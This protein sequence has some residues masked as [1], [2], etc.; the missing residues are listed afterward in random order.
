MATNTGLL[1]NP[2]AATQQAPGTAPPVTPQTQPVVQQQPGQQQPMQ[3]TAAT[4]PT[5]NQAGTGQAV[6]QQVAPK[7]GN[8]P[9]ATGDP[10]FAQSVQDYESALG[11]DPSIHSVQGQL[12]GLLSSDNKLVQQSRNRA[13]LESAARGLRNSSVAV[14]AG[15]EAAYAAALPIAQADAELQMKSRLAAFGA[16]VEDQMLQK[17]HGFDL[18]KIEKEYQNNRG[19]AEQAFGFN[20]QLAHIEGGYRMDAAKL[21]AATQKEVAGMQIEATR[22]ENTAQREWQA[23]QTQQ[24]QEWQAAQTDIQNAW[25]AGQT[26]LQQQ[27]QASQNALEQAF[28]AAQAGLDR[29]QQTFLASTEMSWKTTE[30][31]LD[32]ELKE[33]LAREE[34]SASQKGALAGHFTSLMT[35]ADATIA[36]IVMSDLKAHDKTKEINRVQ[37][38]TQLNWK[39]LQDYYNGSGEVF[40]GFSW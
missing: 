21:S 4:Q 8:K 6:A 33:M 16:A 30:N 9:L 3:Q 24:Q 5:V 40:S 13:S 38:Q 39:A 36:N 19:L 14:Q 29:E 34:I 2:N 28:K 10:A 35:S 23:G 20:K 12:E 32:R 26:D 31:A 27:W 37:Q 15:E 17:Q 22:E 11:F 7:P 1:A 18:E 25:Q